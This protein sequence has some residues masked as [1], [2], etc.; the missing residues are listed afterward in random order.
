MHSQP[1]ACNAP[2]LLFELCPPFYLISLISLSPFY[3]HY[4]FCL[5]FLS[6]HYNINSPF[7]SHFFPFPIQYLLFSLSTLFPS[8]FIHFYSFY[9]RSLALLLHFLSLS[10]TSLLNLLIL[11]K[12]NKWPT[13]LVHHIHDMIP[14]CWC[15]PSFL[16]IKKLII[17]NSSPSF[18]YFF[19]PIISIDI[20][21]LGLLINYLLL[22]YHSCFIFLPKCFCNFLILVP[23]SLLKL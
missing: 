13:S 20:S 16:P 11:I 19:I 1:S 3:S 15:F 8:I 5:I 2:A 6:L 17:S 21:L 9:F 23:Y 4:R 14:T 18:I 10:S 22:K 7:S 12:Y